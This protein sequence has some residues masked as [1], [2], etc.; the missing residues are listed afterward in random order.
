MWIMNYKRLGL[1]VVNIHACL[2]ALI[3]P[4]QYTLSGSKCYRFVKVQLGYSAA[5]NQCKSERGGSLVLIETSEIQDNIEDI[6]GSITGEFYI[7]IG[8]IVT[9]GNAI[10]WA[11]Q[12][13]PG[14]LNWASGGSPPSGDGNTGKCGVFND[15]NNWQWTT[16]TDC[17]TARNYVCEASP[18]DTL[19]LAER[20]A[21]NCS[22]G[23][24]YALDDHCYQF[25]SEEVTWPEAEIEC[26]CYQGHL[27]S[28][29]SREESN[30]MTDLYDYFSVD[31]NIWI[32]L[33]RNDS[34][35]VSWSDG[36]ALSTENFASGENLDVNNTCV[37]MGRQH[38]NWTVLD[39]IGVNHPYICKISKLLVLPDP[40]INVLHTEQASNGHSS[41]PSCDGNVAYNK[42][43]K[44]SDLY[45][46]KNCL[47]SCS[48]ST[49]IFNI[50][51]PDVHNCFNV[52]FLYNSNSTGPDCENAFKVS[53]CDVVSERY[54]Q[55]SRKECH[56]SCRCEGEAT[57]HIQV[58]TLEHI[59]QVCSF[60]L[61]Y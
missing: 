53:R 33:S 10:K 24:S 50:T 7:G 55:E 13:T 54:V 52:N 47:P 1:F 43:E 31:T 19:I 12:S 49:V 34:W 30:L 51:I 41:N 32:G 46:D 27:V 22:Y 35:T 39:C 6:V 60:Q 38:G 42:F 45:I 3:C 16:K 25:F 18:N 36:S 48:Q 23:F 9:N 26:Q 44:I 29:L 8:N 15:T 11:D 37:A 21:Q 40:C 61:L 28:I 56:I 20:N 2:A 59:V 57:C 5:N 14:Y 17:S 4:A 58:L